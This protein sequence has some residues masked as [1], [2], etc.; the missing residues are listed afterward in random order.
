LFRYDWGNSN[1][2]SLIN[3]TPTKRKTDQL[4]EHVFCL[5]PFA[6]ST[7]PVAELAAEGNSD[8]SFRKWPVTPSETGR[9]AQSRVT[10]IPVKSS[11]RVV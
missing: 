7:S 11:K 5:W 9:H 1:A 6:L 4:Y 8:P 10:G 3:Y 2:D